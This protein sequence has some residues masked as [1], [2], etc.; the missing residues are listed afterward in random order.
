MLCLCWSPSFEHEG[1]Q[2]GTWEAMGT[3]YNAQSAKRP[4]KTRI[5]VQLTSA[6]CFWLIPDHISDATK[7]IVCLNVCAQII[8][9]NIPLDCLF[10]S[11]A[12]STCSMANPLGWPGK[13]QSC[14]RH[15]LS[16]L[17][18]TL[19][20]KFARFTSQLNSIKDQCLCNPST[21]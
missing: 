8:H 3:R 18:K 7:L 6:T 2:Q 1:K 11:V 15:H 12:P 4:G 5:L 13:I 21:K 14:A 17:W 10:V 19:D 9:C 16:M 20:L